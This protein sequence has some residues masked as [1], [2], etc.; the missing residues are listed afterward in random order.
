MFRKPEA[1]H[2]TTPLSNLPNR[3]EFQHKL[4]STLG[5][6]HFRRSETDGIPMMAVKMG[7][8]EAQ[9]PLDSL[10]REFAI[11]KDSA[12]G[13]MLDLIG[14]ALDYVASLQPGDRL[15]PEV[16]TGEA[17]WRPNADHVR[18]V[19]T[20]LRLDLIAWMM[21]GSPWADAD[22]DA[23]GLLQCADDPA[24]HEEAGRASGTVA[25]QLGLADGAGVVRLLDDLAQELAYIEA[26]RERLQLRV[27]AL[28][29]RLGRLMQDR[30]RPAIS[31]DTLA[32]V[33]R[34]AGTAARQIVGRFDEVDAQ[35][36]EIGSLL[37]NAESQ[38]SFIRSN[39]DWLY[40]TLRAWEP[41]LDRWDRAANL[42]A[43]EMGALL[44][45]TYQFLAQR[46]LPATQWQRP[47][48]TRRSKRPAVRMAW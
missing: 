10:R 29:R 20:R 34:L 6:V 3:C 31:F 17:S 41:V 8:R 11:I 24:L 27:C 36:G 40:C 42:P 22:R 26:L 4:F 1:M 25:G 21:P 43:E 12:D 38:R 2:P 7:E 30:K 48:Q 14:S 45:T 44:A 37:R 23:M 16:C 33:H 47:G 13:R 5:D 35:T 39:R 15:P 46:F 18:L 32:P 28:C 9:L 19:A